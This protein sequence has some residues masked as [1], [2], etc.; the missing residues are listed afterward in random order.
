MR[1]LARN[2]PLQAFPTEV[3]LSILIRITFAEL[4]AAA[5]VMADTSISHG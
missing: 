3:I 4:G 2:T 5:E 1:F